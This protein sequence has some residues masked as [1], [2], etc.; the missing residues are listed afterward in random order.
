MFKSFE[1]D[2]DTEAGH[3]RSG[4]PFREVPIVNLF[5]KNYED[6]E[7]Y[8][9]EEANLTNEEYSESARTEEV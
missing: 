7:F 1:N 4:T 9:G 5:K 6:E 2:S 3:T 8:S